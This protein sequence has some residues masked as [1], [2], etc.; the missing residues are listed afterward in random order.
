[1]GCNGRSTILVVPVAQT[2]LCPCH[3]V[4]GMLSSSWKPIFSALS[5]HLHIWGQCHPPYYGWGVGEGGW[6][7]SPL[8]F[9]ALSL[10]GLAVSFGY[11]MIS[12]LFLNPILL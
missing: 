6:N 3:L 10:V 9:L 8:S 4:S 7:M 12:V 2:P 5:F 11:D 1:M